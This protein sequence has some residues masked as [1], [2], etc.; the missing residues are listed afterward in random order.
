LAVFVV[1]F[2]FFLKRFSGLGGGGGPP[3]GGEATAGGVLALALSLFLVVSFLCFLKRFNGLGG[4]GGPPGGGP[5][6]AWENA[7][8]ETH[9][10]AVINDSINKYF[11]LA[12]LPE[13]FLLRVIG[14]IVLFV[15]DC[16][17]TLKLLK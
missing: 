6:G 4:G 14:E 13:L 5:G 2:F 3:G 17:L 1:S 15:I 16:L 8:A 7:W 12:E 11:G 10:N 9:K